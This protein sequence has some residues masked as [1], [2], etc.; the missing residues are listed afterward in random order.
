MTV[1]WQSLAMLHYLWLLPAM[2]LLLLYA[3]YRRR[4][5]LLRFAEYGMLQRLTAQLSLARR[6]WKHL[7]FLLAIALLVI[8]L[9]RPSWNP[10]PRDIRRQGRDVVFVLDVS[11]S[12]LAD[13]L[14]PNRL[15][16]A[17]LAINDCLD[18]L[19][20][21]RIGL[22]VF[23]G[24]AVVRC[25]LTLDYGFFRMMLSDVD[26]NS[27]SRGGTMLGD[28]MRKAMR[29]IFDNQ[30]RQYKDLVLITD[31]EDQGSFPVEAA[32][33]L[34]DMGVRI[35]AVGLGDEGDG[36]PLMITD[37]QG[38]RSF[39]KY[40]GQV[41]HSRLD[42]DTLREMV[43]AT[44]GGRYLPVGTGNVDLGAV[45]RNL[46]AT[47][48]KRELESQT[49]ERYEEKFQIFLGAALFLLVVESLLSER[50]KRV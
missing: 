9:A 49:I 35:L 32:K 37:E 12:M 46:I 21:D 39:L 23:A 27:V 42:A 36:T 3:G 1:V 14:K 17:K 15:E 38:R 25:P 22:L 40:E 31:G 4:Q 30:E 20:G 41:V 26:T 5:A 47:A 13:D 50:R 7:L 16:R 43:A 18:V 44:P 24:T 33:Q 28:A 48:E 19:E 6:R 8:A 2:L 10:V 29:D 11:K 45:Y 34:G